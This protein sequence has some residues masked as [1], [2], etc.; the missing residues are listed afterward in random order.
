VVNDS[1]KVHC[2][3][4]TGGLRAQFSGLW[5]SERV[6]R[7]ADAVER[8]VMRAVQQLRGRAA[9][10]RAQRLMVTQDRG[11]IFGLFC[12]SFHLFPERRVL[13]LQIF[14]LLQHKQKIKDIDTSSTGNF[15]KNI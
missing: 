2:P 9:Q 15:L 10:A 11:Q 14:T 8:A 1:T 3:S 6:V 13:L 4:P 7:H 12:E 5:R